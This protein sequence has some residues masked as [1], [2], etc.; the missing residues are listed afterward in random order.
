MTATG[1]ASII[2][3]DPF[4]MN[5]TVD[6]N[7]TLIGT[8]RFDRAVTRVCFTV[9]NLSPTEDITTFAVLVRTHPSAPFVPLI[10]DWTT[11]SGVLLA[12][13]EDIGTL[14]A[15]ESAVAVIAPGPI[16]AI[17]FAAISSSTGAE[18]QIYGQGY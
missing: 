4:E 1:Y 9:G 3:A 12:T 17:Q 6:D 10:A 11:E 7:P 18:I 14:A 16:D 13:S 15:E 2:T 5:G 8:Y